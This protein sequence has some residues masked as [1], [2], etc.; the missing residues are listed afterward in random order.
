MIWPSGKWLRRRPHHLPRATNLGDFFR[1]VRTYDEEGPQCGPFFR[2]QG[3]RARHPRRA[4]AR[5]CEQFASLNGVVRFSGSGSD[6]CMIWSVCADG[7]LA[8]S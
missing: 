3:E 7:G 2:L 1:G 6:E 5:N 8:D 4:G